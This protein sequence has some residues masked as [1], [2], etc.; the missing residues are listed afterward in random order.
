M[1]TPIIDSIA[2]DP[3]TVLPGGRFVVTIAAHDPDEKQGIL[4]GV[5]KDA[6]GA[7]SRAVVTVAISDPLTFEL[8]DADGV[9]FQILPRPGSPG[10]F[11]CTAP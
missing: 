6:A 11:D 3:S 1:S 9:G 10:V 7:E 2:A 4:T 8:L 5:V